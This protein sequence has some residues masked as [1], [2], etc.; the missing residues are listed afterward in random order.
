MSD[1]FNDLEPNLDPDAE[2]EAR[3]RKLEQEEELSAFRAKMGAAP[4]SEAAGAEERFFLV[5]C[6]ECSGKNRVSL[7]RVR[8]QLPRCGRCKGSLSF[9]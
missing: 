1:D 4:T 9:S 6:P 5:L 7:E 3:F 8:R 2:V